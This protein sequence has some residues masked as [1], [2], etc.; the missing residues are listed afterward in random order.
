MCLRSPTTEEAA[1]HVCKW[2]R[3]HVWLGELTPGCKLENGADLQQVLYR[4]AL[5]YIVSLDHLCW[6]V[7]SSGVTRKA[8]FA[9]EDTAAVLC[10]HISR[11]IIGNRA[12]FSKSIFSTYIKVP[13]D[14]AGTKHRE[15]GLPP[16][17]CQ[18][19]PNPSHATSKHEINQ[20]NSCTGYCHLTRGCDT[21]LT[22]RRRK[23]G[24]TCITHTP[25]KPRWQKQ[26]N[27]ARLPDRAVQ[28]VHTK[29]P[30]WRDSLS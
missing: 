18:T 29:C 1:I 14:G 4:P 15:R 12:D 26:H 24:K 3:S 20:L 7:K 25:Q 11:V 19:S 17:S 2:E 27:N 5:P 8:H 28:A 10:Q 30:L 6:D 22:T 21:N 9:H 16:C 13:K 23:H